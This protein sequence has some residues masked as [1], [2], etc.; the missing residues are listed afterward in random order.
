MY[1]FQLLQLYKLV[2]LLFQQYLQIIRSIQ[3]KVPNAHIIV[4]NLYHPSNSRYQVYSKT[5]DSWNN[6]LSSQ[7]NIGYKIIE[8]NKLLINPEDFVYDIEP[9][10]E[11]SRKIAEIDWQTSRCFY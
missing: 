5:I 6:L 2:F 3:T 10:N 9:S 11:G 8:T 7:Q 4:L 1:R